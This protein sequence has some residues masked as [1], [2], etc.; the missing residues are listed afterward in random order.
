M[1]SP[2]DPTSPLAAGKAARLAWV[3]TIEDKR[4]IDPRKPAEQREMAQEHPVRSEIAVDQPGV[5]D[6]RP[7]HDTEYRKGPM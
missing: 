7:A 2:G 1:V 3:G 6:C 5:L 4:C